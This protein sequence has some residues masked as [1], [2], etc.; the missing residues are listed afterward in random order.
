MIN[1]M[2]TD[3]ILDASYT[4]SA[5]CIIEKYPSFCWISVA[6]GPPCGA[7]GGASSLRYCIAE[8]PPSGSGGM[9]SPHLSSEV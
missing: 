6:A 7:A 1:D 5:H 3:Y 2:V 9:T 4:V 8:D